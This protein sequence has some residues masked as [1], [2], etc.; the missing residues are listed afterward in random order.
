MIKG[1]SNAIYCQSTACGLINHHYPFS[2]PLAQLLMMATGTFASKNN[3][4]VRVLPVQVVSFIS[5]Q[6]E[7]TRQAA[8]PGIQ[9][10]LHQSISS[11]LEPEFAFKSD[12]FVPT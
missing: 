9:T 4:S 10:G 3:Q 11:G 5:V 1:N 6:D 12:S 8:V 2:L 7:T